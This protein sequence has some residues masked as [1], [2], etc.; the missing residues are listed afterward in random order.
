MAGDG[1]THVATGR[2]QL[3]RAGDGA[4]RR[5]ARAAGCRQR[6]AAD[7]GRYEI[8]DTPIEYRHD[9]GFTADGRFVT[10]DEC[11][12]AA[13]CS[14]VSRRLRASTKRTARRG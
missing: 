7:Q 3:R 2:R 10:Q 4:Q 14:L 13:W 9:T 5:P 11:T 12:T 8:T 1:R 6:S